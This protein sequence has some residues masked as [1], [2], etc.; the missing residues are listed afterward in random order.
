M[1]REKER[2]RQRASEARVAR[3]RKPSASVRHGESRKA[4]R[5]RHVPIRF[6]K[7]PLIWIFV[8]FL[9]FLIPS[10]WTL[11]SQHRRMN[12]L[13]AQLQALQSEKGEL[14]DSIAQLKAELKN[15]NTDAFIAKQAH[16]KLGMIL[17][18][19]IIYTLQSDDSQAEEDTQQSSEQPPQED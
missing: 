7:K 10:L 3:R 4:E 14:E 5:T 8:I 12:E 17:P 13:Q 16:E 1:T 18:N 6:N 15:V 2:E 11:R 19:E 9:L